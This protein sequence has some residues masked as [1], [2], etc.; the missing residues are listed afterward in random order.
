M[1]YPDESYYVGEFIA[2][3]MHGKGRYTWTK[4]G[5]WFEGNYK[6]NL[7]EGNGTYHYS[8]TEF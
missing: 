5:N 3:K 4:T 1:R 7:R 8:D 6:D 2:G